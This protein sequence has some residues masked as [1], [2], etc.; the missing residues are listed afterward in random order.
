M[1]AIPANWGGPRA[2]IRFTPNPLRLEVG[3]VFV[4]GERRN[5]ETALDM[6]PH[7]CP[8]ALIAGLV[9]LFLGFS[10]MAQRTATAV[11]TV[12]N[13][14]VVAITVTDGGSGY[15]TPP[16]ITITGGN[17]TG[18]SATAT[19]LNGAVDKVIVGNAGS[20]Y[21]GSPAVTIA[22]P[23]SPKPPFSDGLVA[24]YPF[25]GNANDESGNGNNGTVH[26]ALL[27][28]DRFGSANSTF[29]FD[30]TSAY[31]EVPSSTT[32][33]FAQQ[34]TVSAW[35][36]TDHFLP[37]QAD[38]GG[39]GYCLVT[40]GRD[41]EGKDD[42]ACL[43]DGNA[44]RFALSVANGWV[45]WNATTPLSASVWQQV[46]YSFDGSKMRTFLNGQISGQQPAPGTFDIS[47]GSVRIGAY[48]PVNGVQSKAF[49][50]GELDDVRIYNRALTEQEIKDLYRYEAPDQPSVSIAVQTVEVT[51]HV[52]PTKKYQLESSFDMKAWTKVGEPIFAASSEIPVTVNVLQTGQFFRVYEVP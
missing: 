20:G 32:L 34:I 11:P 31:I 19:V 49:F 42:W 41:I 51:L 27:A 36:R 10:A 45:Y 13:G 40:K 14:F 38:G 48:A 16:A 50:R 24:Y 33:T 12:V 35:M 6:K 3:P 23:P 21:T 46:I 5:P 18:A 8:N 25:N 28:A 15:A 9:L 4:R 17:G 47:A 29:R 1:E 7:I 30:G 52:K 44:Q 2:V 22:P 26:G 37:S 43:V 39:S